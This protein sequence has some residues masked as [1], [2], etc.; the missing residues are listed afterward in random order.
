MFDTE[1][2][3]WQLIELPFCKP[4]LWHSACL[5]VHNEVLIYGGCTSNILDLDRKPVSVGAFLV[6]YILY[7]IYIFFFLNPGINKNAY[8]VIIK[9]RPNI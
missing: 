1:A 5:N 2:D 6:S 9:V 7:C 3:L 4:R 8:K